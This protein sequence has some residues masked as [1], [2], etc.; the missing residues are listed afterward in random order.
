MGNYLMPIFQFHSKHGWVVV[1]ALL[2]LFWGPE[3]IRY[4]AWSTYWVIFLTEVFMWSL[5]AVSFNLLMG[6][7][8][9][10]SFGQAA[11]MGLGAYTAGLLLKKISG[12]PF[13]LGLLIS[14]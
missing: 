4:M 1:A 3:F 8:G 2:L 10:I 9:M 14:W 6:Y 7:T 5:F 12:F 11:Y 13:A